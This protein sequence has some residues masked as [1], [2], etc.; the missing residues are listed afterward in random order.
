M[1]SQ[2]AA[3]P[4]ARRTLLW[5]RHPAPRRQAAIPPIAVDTLVG[6]ALASILLGQKDAATG[7]VALAA[8]FALFFAIRKRIRAHRRRARDAL[9]CRDSY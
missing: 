3:H 4:A 1:P 8:A 6:T 7:A 5:Y 2:C 9:T